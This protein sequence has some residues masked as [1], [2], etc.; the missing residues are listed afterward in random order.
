M[1][2]IVCRGLSFGYDGSERNVFTNLE[3]VIDTDISRGLAAERPGAPGAGESVGKFGGSTVRF[4]RD[5]DP[6]GGPIGGISRAYPAWRELLMKVLFDHG[7][8]APLRNRLREHL[9]DRSAQ[10]GWELLENG[11]LIRKAARIIAMVSS[12]YV[13]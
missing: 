11:E 2:T 4:R 3:R 7:T 10:R 8:P 9:V 1:S 6:R 12:R 13:T 5:F